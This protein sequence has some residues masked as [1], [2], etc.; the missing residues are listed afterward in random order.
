MAMRNAWT[1][2]MGQED[3]ITRNIPRATVCAIM[4][5]AL[6][7]AIVHTALARGP[8]Y[9]EFY[10]QYV[11]RPGPGWTEALTTSWLADNHPPFFYMLMRATAWMGE[12]QTHRLV[13]LAIA[14]LTT[15][16]GWIVVRC[17]PRLKAA[18]TVL[19][20]L[21]GANFWTIAAAT[22]LRSYFISLCAGALLTLS[23]V[24]IWIAPAADR[25][26]RTA[27]YALTALVCFN[28]HI[29]TTLITGMLLVP[30]VGAAIARR[31]GALL[32]VLLPAPIVAGMIFLVITAFQVPRW[33]S[34]TRTFWLSGGF[35]AARHSIQYA[36]QRT[37]EAN[38]LIL[39]GSLAGT[40]LLC[41][42]FLRARAVPDL[43][44]VLLIAGGGLVLALALLTGIHLAR[45][46]I[47][48][49]YLASAVGSLAVIVALP[50]SR[51]LTAIPRR[52]EALL[53]AI[54]LVAS[55]AAL[56]QNSAK[57]ANLSSWLGTGRLI[58]RTANACSDATVRIDGFWNADVLAMPPADNRQ[59]IPWAYHI[60]AD[61][62]GFSI[63][64]AS[65]RRLSATCPNLFWA[66]HDTRRRFDATSILR[67]IRESGVAVQ[68]ISVYRVGKGWVA[69][70][71][72]LPAALPR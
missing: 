71:K 5:A 64:P 50:C 37:F 44:V 35:D 61:R 21:L 8:W 10:T 32:R 11:T 52:A 2:P 42:D 45:P 43:L 67:H 51:L 24:S 53:L 1:A 58:A 70:D 62:L 25:G 15:A 59:A 56:A 18:G 36:V 23:L 60:V 3:E 47:T 13:N 20:L 54:S 55:I 22:E 33:E 16:G 38:P 66:E 34:N 65:S 6:A 40:I 9:D 63:E 48:E 39:L 14:T 72:P 68:S 41:R 19:V 27:V 12:I 4:L 29:V 57:T 30:F 26:G 17:E 69:S 46:V 31:D 28:T 49:K 7:L